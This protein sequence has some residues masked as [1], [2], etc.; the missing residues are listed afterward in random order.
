MDFTLFVKDN[1]VGAVVSTLNKTVARGQM[2]SLVVDGLALRMQTTPA[3]TAT[4][5][6][7]EPTTGTDNPPPCQQTP[8]SLR[9]LVPYAAYHRTLLYWLNDLFTTA[10]FIPP[11]TAKYERERSSCDLGFASKQLVLL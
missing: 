4:T 5:A 6:A 9:I 1:A 2:G 3:P 11:L 8:L 7:T 10:F